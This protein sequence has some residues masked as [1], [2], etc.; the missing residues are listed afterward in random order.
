MHRVKFVKR[1]QTGLV[2]FHF[3]VILGLFEVAVCRFPGSI[4]D[5]GAGRGSH[6]RSKLPKLPWGRSVAFGLAADIGFFVE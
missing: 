4:I 3:L 2:H 6:R 5:C 1:G